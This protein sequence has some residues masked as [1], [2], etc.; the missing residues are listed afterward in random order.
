MERTE[1]TSHSQPLFVDQGGWLHRVVSVFARQFLRRKFAQLLIEVTSTPPH[2]WDRL[3]T[4]QRCELHRPLSQAA[5]ASM[6]E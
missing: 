4:F 1:P 3:A 2:P 6:P 5:A